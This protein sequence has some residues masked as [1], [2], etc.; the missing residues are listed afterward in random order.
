MAE[1]KITSINNFKNKFTSVRSNLFKL[2]FPNI[3]S[4]DFIKNNFIRG[5]LIKDIYIYCKSTE[6]PSNNMGITNVQYFGRQ[7]KTSG[8]RTFDPINITFYNSQ[9][10][11]ILNFIDWWLNNI[12]RID[13]NSEMFKKGKGK[14]DYFL[15][16][17]LHQLDRRNNIIKTFN[18]YDAFPT[19]RSEIS[20]NMTETDTIEE[21]TV[22]FE[23]QFW[24]TPELNEVD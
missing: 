4:N 12:N 20:L 24:S 6:L 1:D 16:F 9:D 13:N 14:Y 2:T 15:N 23:Y 5:D 21:F 22:T 11:A 8:D 17:D 18:F 7:F 19:K 3:D 10:F